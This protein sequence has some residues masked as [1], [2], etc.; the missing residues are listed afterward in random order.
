MRIK[1]VK[2]KVTEYNDKNLIERLKKNPKELDSYINYVVREYKKEQ[3]LDV[4]LDCLKVAVMAKRGGATSIAKTANL[5]RSGVYKALSNNAKPR[6][7]TFQK[8]L[9]GVGLN[10]AITK[11]KFSQVA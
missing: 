10:L 5:D 3:N 8:I 2:L 9:Y 7:D 11:A 6:I 1:T 4:L